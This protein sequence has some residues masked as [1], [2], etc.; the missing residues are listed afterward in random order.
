MKRKTPV[1]ILFLFLQV[2][3]WC[4]QSTNSN[5]SLG[6]DS[7]LVQ[8]KGHQGIKTGRLLLVSG[9]H[10][11]L[12]TGSYIALDRTWY[13]N[14]PRSSFHFFNDDA[15][16]N[17]MDKGGHLWTCYNISRISSE[18]WHW[19]GLKPSTSIWL[20]GL[21][22]IAYQSIIE[23]QDGF[24]S[25]WGF[26]WGDMTANAVGAAAYISQA[27]GWKE[28][29]IQIK[30]SYWSNEYN[31]PELR[32]RRD[33]LFG[34]SLT[35]QVLKDYNSQTYWI[36][37]NLKSFFPRSNLP[38]W[39]DASLGYSADGMFGARENKWIDKQGGT[40]D[41][42]DIV[43]LRRFFIAPDID[44]TK[45]KTRSKLLRSVFFVLNMVKVPAPALEVNSLGTWKL[46]AIWF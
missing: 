16:W 24:S 9:V 2:S 39:L 45:I 19:T 25:E 1:I 4:Q 7:T 14:Y 40:H 29:R 5:K 31:T 18:M 3:A 43:R 32:T 38:K 30:L 44:L 10:A 12:W 34:R 36:S 37:V 6:N 46:H 35:E 42:T 13:A 20:G 11:A 8:S 22:G 17:Q 15:E 41:R 27:L 23:I 21:S 33:E 26:S 28:Q